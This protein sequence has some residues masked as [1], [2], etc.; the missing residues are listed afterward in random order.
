MS[1]VKVTVSEAG[2]CRRNLQIEVPRETVAG[3]YRELLGAYVKS[4]KLRGFRPGHAPADL[5][6]RHYAR[7]ILKDLKDYLLS[8]GYREALKEQKLTPVSIVDLK[9]ADVA[10]DLPFAFTVTVEVPPQF[11]LPEYKGL[12]L[13]GHKTDVTDAAVEKTLSSLRERQARYEERT[14]RP[15]QMGDL[16]KIDYEGQSDGQP[17][18]TMAPNCADIATGKDFWLMTDDDTFLPGVPAALVG[19]G[20]GDKRE[21]KVV[22]PAGYH[23]KDVAGKSATYNI[24]IKSIREKILPAMDADFLAPFGFELES[25]LRARIR[26]DLQSATEQTEKDRLKDEIVRLL[27]DRTDLS[28]LPKSLVEDEMRL[29]VRDIVHENTRRGATKEQLQEHKD[30]ILTTATRSSNERVR[31]QYILSRIADQEKVE[32]DDREVDARIQAMAMRY[33]RKPAELRAEIE[34]RHSIDG[35]RGDIRAGKTLDLL[36]SLAKVEID[37]SACEEGQS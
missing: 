23:Q 8:H 16:V 18:A 10:K 2:P 3:E 29:I 15:V 1:A 35:L 27:L 25:D 17:L 36:F 19:A 20:L 26:Q 6:E 5:V 28:E 12:V 30:D 13:K 32:V 14:D 22:F 31:I 7:D 4:A 24:E 37:E 11:E 34:E 21:V 33:H 9:D